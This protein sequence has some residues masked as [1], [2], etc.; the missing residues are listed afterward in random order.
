MRFVSIQPPTYTGGDLC[1][2]T[3]LYQS[4]MKFQ[5]SHRRTPVATLR[6]LC[7]ASGQWIWFQSSHRRTPVATCPWRC[8]RRPGRPVSIQPPTYTGGD[9][10]PPG[11]VRAQGVVSI[12]PPTYTG[13]DPIP[14]IVLGLAVMRFNPATDVHR[15][16]RRHRRQ[17]EPPDAL[18]Q[19]S[20]RRTPVATRLLR[21]AV[22]R[23]F[24]V[25]I[26]PP[27]YTGGDL[28]GPHGEVRRVW[29]SIQP[30]TYTGGDPSSSS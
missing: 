18:F 15:W 21:D 3:R 5:S 29:V 4:R 27:T 6:V 17:R 26:Q 20:H 24:T 30:P 10:V 28:R 19:S 14:C 1:F 13:G 25:S 8:S 7:L 2:M 12:Q 9:V 11:G 23:P 22:A 16:R